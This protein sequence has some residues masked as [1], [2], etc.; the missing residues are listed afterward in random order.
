MFR[1]VIDG[2]RP[3]GLPAQPG[4]ADPLKWERRLFWFASCLGLG[5]GIGALAVTQDLP[6]FIL[7]TGGLAA[8]GAVGALLHSLLYNRLHREWAEYYFT[9]NDVLRREQERCQESQ[10]PVKIERSFFLGKKMSVQIEDH[11]HQ[12]VLFFWQIRDRRGGRNYN[13]LIHFSKARCSFSLKDEQMRVRF[14]GR[15]LVHQ[16]NYP[17]TLSKR[18]DERIMDWLSFHLDL[19]WAKLCAG[20]K[21]IFQLIGEIGWLPS[22]ITLFGIMAVVLLVRIIFNQ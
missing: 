18:L 1:L 13:L 4:E 3:L 17:L 7:N 14:S 11:E 5:S 20:P 21:K 12:L 16:K 15:V 2:G 8:L 22:L 10:F 19:F 6:L 9:L